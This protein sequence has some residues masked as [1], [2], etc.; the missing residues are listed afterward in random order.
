MTL[1]FLLAAALLMAIAWPVVREWR[2]A[3]MT[4]K[5]RQRADGRFVDLADGRVHYDW[6]GPADGPV[7]VC[8]HGLTTPSF[9]WRGV[10]AG[11]TAMGYRV[12]VYDLYGRGLSDRPRG[13][14][15]AAF[16]VSQLD[17]LLASQGVRGD[18]TLLGY[19]MGGAIATA[20]AA[21]VPDRIRQLILIA[22]AGCVPARQGS[23]RWVTDLPVLGDWLMLATFPRRHRHGVEAER[24]LPSSVPDI[25][26]RQLAELDYR[27]YVG[28][29]LASLRGILSTPQD[30]EHAALCAKNVPILA[31]WGQDD[32]VIPAASMARL[33]DW[34]PN[35]RHD[36]VQGAGHGLLYTHT[37]AVLAAV[38]TCLSAGTE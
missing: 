37:D 31:I 1:V 5:I 7:M 23:V 21:T 12:L 11:L 16:F 13:R 29:V 4:D 3:P 26:D 18:I 28:A 2:R 24:D 14:Q 36:V 15:D 20:F 27:G 22:P 17:D 8:V 32:T 35:A 30:I 33:T 25:V 38:T 9:V 10:S 34:N 19:S 6:I